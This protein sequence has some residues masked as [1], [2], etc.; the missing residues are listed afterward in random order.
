M[1]GYRVSAYDTPCA[2][3]PSRRTGRWGVAG[4]EVVNYWSTHPYGAWAEVYRYDGTDST[5]IYGTSQRLWVG[6][7]DPSGIVDLTAPEASDWGL[8]AADLVDDDW[9]ACHAA[10]RKMREAGVNAIRAPSAALPG[11]DN[12]V[13]F[14]QRI[15]IEFDGVVEDPEIELPCAVAADA[16]IGVP[17]VLSLVRYKGTPWIAHER[18]R[19][20]LP[21]PLP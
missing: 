19:Q 15:P 20:S 13:L 8:C 1:I 17:D 3:S 21:T 6:R 9:S 5:T 18:V 12:L 7:F 10:A 2:P 14:G 4:G 11:A 16:S